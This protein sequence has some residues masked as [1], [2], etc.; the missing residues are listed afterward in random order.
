[1][2]FVDRKDAGRQLAR[3]L[4]QYRNDLPIIVALPRGG[5]P[6]AA[7]IAQALGAPLELL[8]VRKIGLPH[9]PE[10]AMGAVVDGDPSIV[11]RNEDV[12]AQ[13]RVTD[14]DFAA[15]SARE[16]AE[17]ARRRLLYPG[18]KTMPR[19]LAGRTVILVDDGVAT[20]ATIRVAIRALRLSH[21]ARI[22]L[23]VPVGPPDTVSALQAEADAVVCLEK[24]DNFDA[25][26]RYYQDFSQ[27]DDAQVLQILAQH[28]GQDVDRPGPPASGRRS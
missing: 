8:L 27:L 6:V 28:A 10:L 26:G 24:H 12:I 1:M 17:I 5:V 14:A 18:P 20:G 4:Q 3:A 21:P 19:S 23:A 9:H 11:L 13:A 16:R 25:I 2:P 7:E 15:A 22:I